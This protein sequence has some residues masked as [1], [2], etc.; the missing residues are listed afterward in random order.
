MRLA[1]VLVEVL[2]ELGGESKPIHRGRIIPLAEQRWRDL[3]NAIKGDFGQTVS[4]TIQEYSSDSAE[5]CE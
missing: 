3:G 2:R 1:N 4:A 5:W